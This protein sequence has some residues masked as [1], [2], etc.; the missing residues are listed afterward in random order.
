MAFADLRH[1]RLPGAGVTLHAV[2]AGHGPPVILL[3]GFPEHWRSWRRLI[4]PI[5]GAGFTAIAPDLRG[6]NESDRP[7]AREAYRLDVLVADLAALVRATQAPRAR[8]VGHDWGGVIAWA[9]AARH[10]ALVE[11]LAVLNAP[12]PALYR[13]RLAHPDQLFRSAYVGVFRVPGLAERLLSAGDFALLRRLFTG[14]A[15]PGTFSRE[16]LDAYVAAMRP[17]GALT[18]ALEYYRAN[19]RGDGLAGPDRVTAPTLVVWG[20]RDAALSVRL[21]DGLP[22][23]APALTIRRLPMVGHWVHHEAPSEVLRELMPFLNGT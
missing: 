22:E 1:T 12:H 2:V 9:F 18:A 11:R 19:F 5:A 3:H 23:V 10:P 7:P 16:E 20:E 14:S 15:R 13:R 6:Y 8:I 17:P 4:T 21:L